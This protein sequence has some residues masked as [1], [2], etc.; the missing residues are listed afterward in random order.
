MPTHTTEERKKNRSR[1]LKPEKSFVAT[2][3]LPVQRTGLPVSGSTEEVQGAFRGDPFDVTAPDLFLPRPQATVVP[4]KSAIT[5]REEERASLTAE[6][7]QRADEGFEGLF[8]KP[9]APTIG[10]P[11]PSHVPG[12]EVPSIVAEA[13]DEEPIP[14]PVEETAAIEAGVSAIPG[15]TAP[16]RRRLVFAPAFKQ[17]RE[18]EL[19]AV[20]ARKEALEVGALEFLK[21]ELDSTDF[22]LLAAG[23]RGSGITGG[24]GR[25]QKISENLVISEITTGTD[26]VTGE[27]ITQKVAV[28]RDARGN[29]QTA[30]LTSFLQD[31]STDQLSAARKQALEGV[32]DFP[33]SE[34]EIRE[35]FKAQYGEDL[36]GA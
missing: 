34:D 13:L 35:M 30:P 17:A 18:G 14:T 7:A 23:T 16:S 33:D 32:S 25:T 9:K 20:R 28:T 22:A 24:Q 4:R 29:I 1:R 15:Q 21:N 27:P 5:L 31:V 6:E 36:G 3:P 10:Q 26:P 12:Q 19:A 11:I 2:E 8:P